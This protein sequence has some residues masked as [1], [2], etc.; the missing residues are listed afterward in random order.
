MT[1]L[2]YNFAEKK[3]ILQVCL[4]NYLYIFFKNLHRNY[5]ESLHINS[6]SK[7]KL[8]FLLLEYIPEI[9]PVNM[10]IFFEISNSQVKL[11]TVMF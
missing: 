6:Q 8:L 2:Q 7:F 4:L 3:M 11:V 10:L 9:D 5:F 1:V